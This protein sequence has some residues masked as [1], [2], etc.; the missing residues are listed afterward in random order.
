MTVSL[1]K[2]EK[3]R[4]NAQDFPT[5]RLSRLKPTAPPRMRQKRRPHDRSTSCS[6]Q[7]RL[8][9]GWVCRRTVEPCIGAAVT[10]F[11]LDWVAV[12]VS[13]Q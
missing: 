13:Y 11:S 6:L 10:D 3:P 2:N 8:P 4:D 1:D 7:V 12:R 5:T 9:P